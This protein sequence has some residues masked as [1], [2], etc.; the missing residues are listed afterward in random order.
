MGPLQEQHWDTTRDA[1][2]F[3]ARSPD[4]TA[5]MQYHEDLPGQAMWWS[6][7]GDQQGDGWTATFTASTLMYVVQAFSTAL[8]SSEPVMRPRGHVPHS[9][10]I[11]IT[12]VS[13]SPPV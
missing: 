6:G 11:R 8:A 12:S 3:N 5:W 2:Q 1:G 7:A 10:K 4:G 9:S 13:S